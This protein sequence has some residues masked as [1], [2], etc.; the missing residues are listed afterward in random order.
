MKVQL[1]RHATLLVT[2]GGKNILVDPMLGDTGASPPIPGSCDT[3]RNPLVPL[4]MPAAA[5]I[6][7]ADAALVTHLHRDHLDEGASAQLPKGLP[8]FCQPT[9]RERL[10]ALGFTAVTAVQDAFD[11]DGI[12]LVRFGGKHGTG[13]IGVLMGSVSGFVLRAAGEPSLY[14][15][16]DSIWCGEVR[17]ALETMHPDVVVVNAG[18]AQF[19]TGSP[20]TM[21]TADIAQVCGTAPEARVVA[22]HMD[23]INHC[24]LTRDRLRHGLEQ[25]GL[26]G[27]V[28]IP[29]DGETLTF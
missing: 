12:E 15:A 28:L 11:F 20:I 26:L 22:V 17:E 24:L 5:V 13:L 6:A 18:A 2:I 7:G 29:A 9:D 27:R 10:Q 25:Q 8:L 14:I 23:S 16:G 19:V 3:R 21:G 1:I 4:P